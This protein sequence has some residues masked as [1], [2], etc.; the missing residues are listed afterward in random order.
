MAGFWWAFAELL[1]L[2]AKYVPTLRFIPYAAAY[3]LA[4]IFLALTVARN[5]DWDSDKSLF[6]A[7]LKENPETQRVHFNLAVTY[8][9]ILDNPAGARR[10]FLE[11][12]RIMQENKRKAG[13]DERYVSPEELEVHLSLGKVNEALGEYTKAVQHYAVVAAL[14]DNP[15]LSQ[16]ATLANYRL[17]HCFLAL[18]DMTNANRYLQE[19]II[20]EPSLLS[21][22]D[23]LLMGAPI[24]AS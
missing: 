2:G 20:K 4:V 22:V 1:F 9:D 10:H 14:K 13:Q 3:T 21:N 17:G 19:A 6:Q 12:L 8:E 15:M 18:G 5:H 7:T 24:S 23:K 11:V 16:M